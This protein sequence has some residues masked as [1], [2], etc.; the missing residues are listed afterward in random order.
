MVMPGAG[1]GTTQEKVEMSDSFQ[2]LVS[3]KLSQKGLQPLLDAERVTVDIRTDLSPAALEDIIPNYDALLVRS[4]TQVT[5]D[6]IHAG[7]RLQA[8]GRAGTGVDNIDVEAATRAGVTVVNTPTGNTVAAAEHTI[9]M[10]M[11]LARNIPQADRDVRANQWNRS[12]FVGT[13]VRDKALG[14]VGLGRIAQEVLQFAQSLGMRVLAH[15]PFVSEE[16]AAQRGATLLSLD[17]MLPQVDFL[18]VHV[19]LTDATR[20]MIDA[21]R[22]K[23]MKRGARVLNV[24]R[25]G[26]INEKALA[27]AVKDGHISGAALDVF[28]REPLPIESPLRN[29]EKIILTPHLGA[30]TVEAMDRVAEDV[31][32]QVLDILQGRPARNAVNAP[33]LPPTALRTI[34][35]YI[36]LAERLGRFL[37]QID[38]QGITRLEITGHGPVTA[39]DMAYVVASAIRGVLS[40]IVEERVNLVNAELLARGRGIEI[41]QRKMPDHERYKSMITLRLTSAGGTNTVL[42]TVLLDE[43]TFVAVND[44]WVE[45]PAT[46]NLLLASHT[47]RPGIIGKVG[48]L[49]GRSDVNISFMHVGR[50]APRGEAIMVL[51]T[52]EQ[53]PALVL[54]ELAEIQD[55]RWLKVVDLREKL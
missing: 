8:I 10:L 50:R 42:G 21:R 46:G 14:I 22:L 38:E 31:S 24:A 55:I 26:I 28:E 30:S 25:G 41:V 27:A 39:F 17:D 48:T 16:Y 3:D 45:F 2:V 51:G 12:S 1:A 19:P 5:A 33:I 40:D 4:S 11:A 37:R 13:E 44:Q 29:S 34:I 43:P 20:N 36:D 7:K 18:T 9:A 32:V 54:K 53:T 23:Q 6:V 35:P 15:D 47:D 49:L 52:D